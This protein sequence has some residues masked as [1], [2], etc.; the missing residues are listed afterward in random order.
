MHRQGTLEFVP[1]FLPGTVLERHG[2]SYTANRVT[3][4]ICGIGRN[5]PECYQTL[6][7]V[8]KF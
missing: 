6:P 5:D 4:R 1:D 3:R 8:S 7:K 2:A